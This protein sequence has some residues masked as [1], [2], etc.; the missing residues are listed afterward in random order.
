MKIARNTNRSLLASLA[1]WCLCL[2]LLVSAGRT[3][4]ID[5]S[6]R[7]GIGASHQFK[8]GVPAL[9]F[10]L[11]QSPVFAVGG[12]LGYRDGG[13]QSDGH[14]LGVKFYRR[15]FEESQLNFYAACLV[16]WPF[17]QG[18]SGGTDQ[19]QLDF[20]LGSEFH[21]AGLESLGFSLEFGLSAHKT[22]D[23]LA[24]Q[25]AGDKFLA[26]SVHFYL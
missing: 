6:G 13:A 2:G 24:I 18:P 23:G 16:V 26:S 12:L 3:F 25:T 14:G 15:L 21:F 11:Q 20:T 19:F 17:K 8:N 5:R 22:A 7:L 1:G 9:S 4:A 10:K